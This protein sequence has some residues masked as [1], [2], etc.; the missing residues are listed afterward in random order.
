M[1]V[2][3]RTWLTARRVLSAVVAVSVVVLIASGLLLTYRY[4]PSLD[5]GGTARFWSLPQVVRRMHRLF[6]W[7]LLLVAAGLTVVTI[8]DRDGRRTTSVGRKQ[9]PTLTAT[10]LV[11]LSGVTAFIGFLLP[12]DLLGVGAVTVGTNLRGYLPILRSSHYSVRFVER[13]SEQM[14]PDTVARWFWLHIATAALLTIVVA[15]M[16]ARDWVRRSR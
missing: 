11:L 1:I 12:W 9:R 7:L 10:V 15:S 14:G 2:A 5:F 3:R 6:A 16:L 8:V 13:G 4:L